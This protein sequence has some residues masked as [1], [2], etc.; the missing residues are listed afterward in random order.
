MFKDFDLVSGERKRGMARSPGEVESSLELHQR[1]RWTQAH[2]F[3]VSIRISRQVLI[4]LA[5]MR[6][7]KSTDTPTE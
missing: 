2:I 7:Q 1:C 4:V 6:F 3:E 5:I